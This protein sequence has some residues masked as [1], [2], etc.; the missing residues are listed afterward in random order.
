MATMLLTDPVYPGNGLS[1][2]VVTER[3]VG[4]DLGIGHHQRH[5]RRQ[6]LEGRDQWVSVRIVLELLD[7]AGQVLVGLTVHQQR[8]VPCG[9]EEHIQFL[10]HFHVTGEDHRL[11]G[12]V[13]N[14]SVKR[15]V[16]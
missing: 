8:F 2:L 1:A 15:H 13:V 11:A 4:E 6:R 10:D 12:S 5:C 9:F 14:D 7:D 3:R 16:R